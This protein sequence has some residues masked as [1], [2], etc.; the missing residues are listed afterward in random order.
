M[1]IRKAMKLAWEGKKV[2]RKYWG[3]GLYCVIYN[4]DVVFCNEVG[5]PEGDCYL[6]VNDLIAEDWEAVE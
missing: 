3:S 2:R 4:T 6:D 1:K 5:D